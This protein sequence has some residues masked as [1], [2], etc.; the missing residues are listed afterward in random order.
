MKDA[1]NV[2]TYGAAAAASRD[3]MKRAIAEYGAVTFS[4]NNMHEYEFYNPKN[5]SGAGSSPHACTIIGWD[6]NIPAEKFSPGVTSQ[7]GGWLVK[8]SY[9]SLPY[10]WLSYEYAASPST[11]AFIYDTADKY[12]FNYFYDSDCDDLYSTATYTANIFTAKKGTDEKAEQLQAVNIG[13]T[14]KNVTCTV[15]V[16]TDLADNSDPTG[17]KLAASASASYEHAGY[18][19]IELDKNVTLTPGSYFS[20]AV[21]VSNP[22]NDARIRTADNAASGKCYQNMGGTW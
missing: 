20:I 8:N 11:W 22:K 13:F 17:G 3:M 14:G 5:E 10:F 6:D 4:Y 7:D 18:Y 1:A 2:Y 9:N 16:Y 21:R 19:T 15:E 12:D